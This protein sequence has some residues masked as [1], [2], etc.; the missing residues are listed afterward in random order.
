MVNIFPLLQ[1]LAYWVAFTVISI[2]FLNH[3]L[4]RSIITGALFGVAM[5]LIDKLLGKIQNK[6]FKG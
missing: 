6:H 2:L 4:Q 1:L 5:L 3:D